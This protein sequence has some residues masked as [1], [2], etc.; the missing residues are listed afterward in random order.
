MLRVIRKKVEEANNAIN[1]KSKR[2]EKVNDCQVGFSNGR[3]VEDHDKISKVYENSSPSVEFE[4]SDVGGSNIRPR[5][6]LQRQRIEGFQNEGR[7]QKL[8]SSRRPDPPIGYKGPSSAVGSSNIYSSRNIKYVPDR[9]MRSKQE[10]FDQLSPNKRYEKAPNFRRSVPSPSVS[11]PSS[12]SRTRQKTHDE[13]RYPEDFVNERNLEFKEEDISSN[14]S[15]KRLP[16]FR[17]SDPSS[18]V[19]SSNSRSRTRQDS[20]GA[21]KLLEDNKRNSYFKDNDLDKI[22]SNQRR[23]KST[24]FHQFHP[25]PD[26]QEDQCLIGS[27]SVRPKTKPMSSDDIRD[28]IEQNLSNI[29]PQKRQ[30]VDRNNYTDSLFERK[31]NMANLRRSKRTLDSQW[32]SL[33]NDRDNV[34]SNERRH[35]LS[36]VRPERKKTFHRNFDNDNQSKIQEKSTNLHRS[37]SF[38]ERQR[39]S[40]PVVDS[41]NVRPQPKQNGLLDHTKKE[42]TFEKFPASGL[43]P[44]DENFDKI[45]IDA[46]QMQISQDLPFTHGE[47]NAEVDSWRKEFE[48][49]FNEK[50]Q[51]NDMVTQVESM[52]EEGK[53]DSTEAFQGQN[54]EKDTVNHIESVSEAASKNIEIDREREVTNHEEDV[55]ESKEHIQEKH[56]FL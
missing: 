46:S 22:P 25:L 47:P 45:S 48:K 17:R 30:T 3:N 19:G 34:S 51:T 14:Q 53:K 43:R 37:D 27:P 8:Y 12:L 4:P 50:F 2:T 9:T 5:R 56:V 52:N 44:K 15:Q 41:R 55:D 23:E 33:S 35:N 29:R 6:E 32:S 54:D 28:E 1:T 26:Y 49:D 40:A 31:Q 24:N 7:Q 10:G 39:W 13:L 42:R 11:S 38:S 16:T 21:L 20:H 18:L 36:N